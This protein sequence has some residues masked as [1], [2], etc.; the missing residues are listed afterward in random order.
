[1]NKKISEKYKNL[2]IDN[3][4][5]TKK[6]IVFS[7]IE[8]LAKGGYEA[9]T[10]KN[11]VNKAGISKG[12]L[13]HHFKSIDDIPVEAIKQLRNSKM[14]LPSLKLDL[15]FS[16]DDYL[17]NYYDLFIENAKERDILSIYLFFDQKSLDN[18]EYRIN[19]NYITDDLL[20]YHKNTIQFFYSKKIPDEIIN[21]I[22]ALIVFTTEGI[23]SHSFMY[24]EPNKFK[25]TWY[26]LVKSIQNDLK[27]Y[28]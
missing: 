26:L 8:L 14:Y 5:D 27:D 28:L 16:I 21:P 11:I 13:Y 3:S 10:A 6:K 20:N 19:K 25:K 7:A 17:N 12:S 22:T 1:M 9:F 15:F 4:H 18:E 24:K 23:T 2:F